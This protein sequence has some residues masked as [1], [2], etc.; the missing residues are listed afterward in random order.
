MQ[1]P[2]PLL[3]LWRKAFPIRYVVLPRHVETHIPPA[4]G[5]TGEALDM[6]DMLPELVKAYETCKP[7]FIWLTREIARLEKKYH[8]PAP[9]EPAALAV[10]YTEHEALN[11]RIAALSRAVRAPLLA[12]DR[13]IQLKELAE[14]K[15]ISEA[16]SK[17]LEDFLTD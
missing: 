3:S 7:A 17:A 9:H 13:I 12:A 10:W 1:W 2:R 15:K 6:D 8:S 4:T 16:E 11:N 5:D 14:K